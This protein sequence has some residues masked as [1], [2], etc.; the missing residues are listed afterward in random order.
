MELGST[1]YLQGAKSD[2]PAAPGLARPALRS[3]TSEFLGTANP[4]NRH[5][6]RVA[7]LKATASRLFPRPTAPGAAPAALPEL[8]E[9]E[10]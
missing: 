10:E 6:H 5:V 1:A 3:E 7:A 9:E 8:A 4:L 2:E